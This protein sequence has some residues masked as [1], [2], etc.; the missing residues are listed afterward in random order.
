MGLG[1]WLAGVLYDQFAFYV[2]AFGAGVA[3][4]LVNI[5]IIAML[6]LRGMS[7]RKGSPALA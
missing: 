3:A 2:P 7:W 5:A 4:N 1:G 6:V